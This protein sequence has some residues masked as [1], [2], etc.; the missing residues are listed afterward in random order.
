M[1]ATNVLQLRQTAKTI[2]TR[3]GTRA[4]RALKR[5]AVM[6]A[7][8]G[9]VALTLTSLSLAHLAHGIVDVTGCEVWES[10]AMA[11]GIDC[12]FVALELAQLMVGDRVRKQIDRF[13]KPTTLG[14]LA[15]SATMNAI[16][17]ASHASSPVA[18]AAAV[19]FGIAIPALIFA[20]VRVSATLAKDC[21]T[22]Q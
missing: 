14:T 17:F 10:W 19:A 7:V 5:Q 18:M 16:A 12:G 21:H 2:R 3:H 4:R 11:V 9:L 13:V 15:G 8:I 1:A 22:R 20:F 6:G